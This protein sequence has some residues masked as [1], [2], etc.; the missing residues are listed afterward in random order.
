[1]TVRK[2]QATVKPNEKFLSPTT[3]TTKEVDLTNK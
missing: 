2:K 3:F 1:M